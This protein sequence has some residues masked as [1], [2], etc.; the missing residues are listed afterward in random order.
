VKA[1]VQCLKVPASHRLHGLH[2][3]AAGVLQWKM[4]S[5][6]LLCGPPTTCLLYERTFLSILST[7][8]LP[9]L[10]ATSA[11]AKSDYTSWVFQIRYECLRPCSTTIMHPVRAAI[12]LFRLVLLKGVKPERVARQVNADLLCRQHSYQAIELHTSSCTTG[13]KNIPQVY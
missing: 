10:K 6:A 11:T 2:N 4:L 12:M 9:L 3:S 1:S 13:H 7:E 5:S 8:S